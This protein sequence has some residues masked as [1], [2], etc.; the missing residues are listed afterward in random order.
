MNID[1]T[2]SIVVCERERGGVQFR[3]Y[4]RIAGTVRVPVKAVAC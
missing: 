1:H 2:N 3:M 4:E